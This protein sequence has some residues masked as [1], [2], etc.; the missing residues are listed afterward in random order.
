MRIMAGTASH[1]DSGKAPIHYL[2]RHTL[3]AMAQVIAYG[4]AKY[5][6]WNWRGGMAWSKVYDS[7]MRHLMAWNS[8]ETQD[9][10]SGLSHL[11]HAACNIMFL[12]QYAVEHPE[13]DDRYKV[14]VEDVDEDFNPREC[15]SSICSK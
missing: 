9:P 5:D 15:Y 12:I 8:G 3:E 13:L 6:E 7:A 11:A 2:D 4:A 1:F 14:P 10:E